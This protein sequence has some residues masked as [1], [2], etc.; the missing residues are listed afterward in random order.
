MEY[1]FTNSTQEAIATLLC[2]AIQYCS[3]FNLLFTEF[4]TVMKHAEIIGYPRERV[5]SWIISLY[6]KWHPNTFIPVK[7]DQ[8]KTGERDSTQLRTKC[9]VLPY[10]KGNSEKNHQACSREWWRT[11]VNQVSGWL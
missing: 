10:A 11:P 8:G 5:V 4:H 6:N 7:K 2:L 1:K 3:D 9:L